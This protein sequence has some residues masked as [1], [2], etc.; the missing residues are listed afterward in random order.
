MSFKKIQLLAQLV[1]FVTIGLLSILGVLAIA[2]GSSPAWA[3]LGQASPSMS[4]R[5]PNVINYQGMLRQADGSVIN[6]TYT[7]TL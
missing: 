3:A 6:G 2:S 4:P 1:G 5:V 7:M